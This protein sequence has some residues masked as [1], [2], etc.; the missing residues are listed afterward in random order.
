[1]YGAAK[2]NAKARTGNAIAVRGGLEE[3]VISRAISGELFM[4]LVTAILPLKA[5]PQSRLWG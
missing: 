1:M 5:S 4:P 2:T 3:W